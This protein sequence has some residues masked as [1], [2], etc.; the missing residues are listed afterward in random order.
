MTET[1]TI[2]LS[3]APNDAFPLSHTFL[4]TKGKYT[5]QAIQ[6]PSLAQSAWNAWG[7]AVVPGANG[8]LAKGWITEF[9]VWSH[10]FPATQ[11]KTKIPSKRWENARLAWQNAKPS[12][13]EIPADSA[14]VS[15]YIGD[16]YED[17]IGGLTIQVTKADL[18]PP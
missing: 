13:F 11:P 1:F 12:T 3:A 5:V 17:N 2:S 9:W 7:G 8:A 4:A 15:I 18:P 14:L 16:R 10:V 6:G